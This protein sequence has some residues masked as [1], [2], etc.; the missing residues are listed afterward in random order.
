MDDYN[1]H[2]VC[3]W[4]GETRC[5]GCGL[6]GMLNCRWDWRLLLGFVALILPFGASS[7]AVFLVAGCLMGS[8]LPPAVYFVLLAIFLTVVETRILCSHCPFYA[9]AG[10]MIRCHANHGLPKPWRYRPGPMNSAERV[11]L[12]SCFLFFLAFPA[13]TGAWGVGLLYGRASEQG[14]EGLLGLVCITAVNLASAV[15][16]IILLSVFYCA[17]CV[18]FSCPFNRVPEALRREYLA[19]NPV[20]EEAWQ[21][22][23]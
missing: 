11:I 14:Q 15:S 17:C 9:R 23:Q 20:L 19:L 6:R 13:V 1:P 22:N 10:R 5:E 16:F 2:G 8:W 7:F 3:T 12:I 4:G 21:G 18:N